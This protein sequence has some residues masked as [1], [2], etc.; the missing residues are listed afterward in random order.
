V[1][2]DRERL[3]RLLTEHAP[4]GGG[5]RLPPPCLVE[6]QGEP[7]EYVEGERPAM[8]IPVPRRCQTPLR[9]MEA[10][11]T[12]AALDNTIEPFASTFARVAPWSPACPRRPSAPSRTVPPKTRAGA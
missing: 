6:R 4:A 9:F 1:S 5:L 12:A 11:P 8:R 2:I 7:V 3:L 10:G